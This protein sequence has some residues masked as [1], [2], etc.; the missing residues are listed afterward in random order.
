MISSFRLFLLTIFLIS[1]LT[2]LFDTDEVSANAH[3]DIQLR[4]GRATWSNGYRP[5]DKDS[6]AL[7]HAR[8]VDPA[9]ERAWR[10]G[11]ISRGGKYP[12]SVYNPN[13]GNRLGYDV[14]QGN[15]SDNNKRSWSI[16][17][18]GGEDFFTFYGWAVNNGYY[19]HDAHNQATYIVAENTESREFKIYKARLTNLNAGKDLEYAKQSNTGPINNKCPNKGSGAFMK[20]NDECNM[21]Y[22]WVGFVAYIPLNDLFVDGGEEWEL[23]IIKAVKG[24]GRS[25][26]LVYDE[27]I[28]PFDHESVSWKDGELTLKSGAEYKTLTMI[29]REVI[30]RT[31]PRSAESGIQRGYFSEGSKYTW[32]RQDESAGV[33]A[34]HGVRSH[35]DGGATRY[36]SS[37]YWQFGG[38]IAKL[39]WKKTK[40]D[41][42]IRHIDAN[43]DTVLETERRNGL[44]IGTTYTFN[45]KPRGTWKDKDGNPFVPI[46]NSKRITIRGDT[47]VDFHYK[48]SIPDP[49]DTE[50]MDGATDGRAKGQFSWELHKISENRES[51]IDIK[52]NFEI[53]GNHY[54]VRDISYETSSSGVFTERGNSPQHLFIDNPNSL[55]NKDIS[56]KFGYEYT[57]HYW[58]NY[59]CVDRQG[60]DCFEWK[61]VNYTPAWEYAKQAEWSKVLRVDHKYGETFTFNKGDSNKLP[62]IISRVTTVDGGVNSMTDRVYRETFTVDRKDTKLN[63][64]TWKEVAETVQYQSELNNDLYVISGNRYYFPNDIDDNL[65]SKYANETIYEFGDYAIPLRIG[66]LTNNKVVFLTEDN[67]F[68]T[69]KTGF[70]FSLPFHETSKNR[71]EVLAKDQ[72]EDYTNKAYNDTVL[73]SPDEGSRYYLNIDLNGEQQPNVEYDDHVVLGK[74]GLND[75]TVQL[76][77]TLEF[78]NYLFGHFKDDPVFVEQRT[79]IIPN[80]DYANTVSLTKDQIIKLKEIERNREGKIHSFRGTDDK[81]I[82]DQVKGIVPLN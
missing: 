79:S 18:S 36:A 65:R 78:D 82:L 53:T 17:R 55:K 2:F 27:L 58:E 38:S 5:S 26:H 73:T 39:T 32:V 48:A 28:I 44:N 40:A 3:P 75:I 1:G 8:D 30:R 46:D 11:N 52:N 4:D 24:Y 66:Q 10:N 80:V 29:T 76:M 37:M 63:S 81:E 33:T 13:K 16:T 7:T 56:Y 45:P 6:N 9:V 69:K 64:Q 23:Y 41:V 70:V 19:H 60:S 42:T 59:E 43:T 62:L 54:A 35:H 77:Q 50:E 47:T 49:T 21:E 12:R 67:F 31:S 57:N 71:I 68:V 15:T 22:K 74:L 34:W 20:Y 61:F 14:Y 51:R 25:T 72:Y